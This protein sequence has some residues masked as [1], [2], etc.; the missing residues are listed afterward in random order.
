MNV[1]VGRY[2]EEFISGVV[3]SG[4]YGSASEVVREG[5]RRVHAEEHKL[6]TLKEMIDDS[7]AEGGEFSEADIEADLEVWNEEAKAKGY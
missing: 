7:I 2:W 5:L 6:K 4:R 3:K 1:S